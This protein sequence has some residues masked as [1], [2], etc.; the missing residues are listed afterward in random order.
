MGTELNSRES[1]LR[2][3]T[4]NGVF[5]GCARGDKQDK[6]A[7]AHAIERLGDEINRHLGLSGAFGE[8][9]LDLEFKNGRLFVARIRKL[10]SIKPKN[11]GS[12]ESQPHCGDRVRTAAS[13]S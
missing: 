10:D 8:V 5:I 2:A 1:K 3:C 13:V 9:G 4:H 11:Q 7:L 6:D 12:T